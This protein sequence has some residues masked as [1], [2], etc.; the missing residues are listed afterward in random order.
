MGPHYTSVHLADNNIWMYEITIGY[1]CY[2]WRIN[3][4]PASNVRRMNG[5]IPKHWNLIQEAVKTTY[6]STEDCIFTRRHT[7][8]NA[9]TP[10]RLHS[11]LTI[12]TSSHFLM[13]AHNLS[14]CA[15]KLIWHSTPIAGWAMHSIYFYQLTRVRNTLTNPKISFNL[16]YAC[17]CIGGGR[18]IDYY[19]IL[20]VVVELL[21]D[22]PA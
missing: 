20:R 3:D 8:T 19:L 1:S 15:E 6:G 14:L 10:V 9:H 4:Q 7:P 22:K 2:K 21:Y 12:T 17:V 13:R 16:H 5:R 11:N 18:A